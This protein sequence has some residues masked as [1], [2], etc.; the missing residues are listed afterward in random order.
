MPAAV[1]CSGGF[2]KSTDVQRS[3]K[4]SKTGRWT[5]LHLDKD[6]PSSTLDAIYFAMFYKRY[7]FFHS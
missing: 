2:T 3:A 1:S 5:P 7:P 4:H 6:F